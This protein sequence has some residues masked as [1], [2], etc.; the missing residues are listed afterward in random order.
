MN[1]NQ[2]HEIHIHGTFLRWNPDDQGIKCL[3]L[4]LDKKLNWNIH[5]NK[6]LTEGYTRLSQLFPLINRKF[7][8]KPACTILMYKS[9]IRR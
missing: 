5:L 2:P 9:I 4:W 3:G 8:L 1:Y 6:K 7:S